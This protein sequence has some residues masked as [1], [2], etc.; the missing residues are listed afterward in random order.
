MTKTQQKL[1]IYLPTSISQ[2]LLLLFFLQLFFTADLQHQGWQNVKCMHRRCFVFSY[3][4]DITFLNT[5]IF[6]YI[7]LRFLESVLQYKLYSE[8]QT[9]TF[10]ASSWRC[11]RCWNCSY[12]KRECN[13]QVFMRI[14]IFSFWCNCRIIM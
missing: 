5:S 1:F 13:G 4:Y 2:L 8:L 11:K 14:S 7:C 12:F 10:N 9:V 3:W 6:F